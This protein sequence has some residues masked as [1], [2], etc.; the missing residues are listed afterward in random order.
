MLRL[1]NGYRVGRRYTVPLRGL[2]L[3]LLVALTACGGPE[4]QPLQLNPMPWAD[5]EQSVYRVTDINGDFAGSATI[6]WNAGAAT[7]DGDAWTMRREILAQGDQEVVV[8]EMTGRGLRPRLSTL[9][10]LRGTAR[11]QVTAVYSGGQV[12][13]ELTT[14]QDVTTTHRE[15]VLSDVRDYRTL[16]QLARALPLREGYATAVNTYLPITNLQERTT[17]EVLEQEAISVPAGQYQTW[18]V[19]LRTGE[20]VSQA[21]IG[22]DAPHILVQFVEGRSGGTF[23]LDAVQ[24]G[25]P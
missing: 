17:I 3:V 13:M 22:V 25:Q 18:L 21:W 6:T 10:R 9:V 24:V 20:T 15:N 12:D 14:A 8:I 23:A 11:E 2:V 1:L 7:I 5:G 4:I 19:E 16:M